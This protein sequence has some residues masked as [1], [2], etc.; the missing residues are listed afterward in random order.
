[1]M[2]SRIEPPRAIQKEIDRADKAA[3]KAKPK[4]SAAMQAGARRFPTTFPK[5]HLEKPGVESELALRPMYDA[6][7]YRGSDKLRDMVALLTGGDSDI[8]RAVAVLYAREGADVA[9]A[10]LD[11][12]ADAEATKRAVEAEGRRCITMAASPI[13]AFAWRRSTEPSRNSGSS[14]SWSTT[15]PSKSTSRA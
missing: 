14:T 9:I 2:R 13:C 1:M 5:Q 8:G 4:K 11:E 12:H 3:G 10:Y 6:P 7:Q 15:R